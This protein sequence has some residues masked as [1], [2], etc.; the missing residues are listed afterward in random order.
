MFVDK[1]KMSSKLECLRD[2]KP[3]ELLEVDSKQFE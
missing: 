3:L 1:Q 2:S